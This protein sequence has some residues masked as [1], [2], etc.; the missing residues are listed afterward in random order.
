M[1]Q[2]TNPADELRRHVFLANYRSREQRTLR[3]LAMAVLVLKHGLR[4]SLLFLPLY[5][6]AAALAFQPG[7]LPYVL[8]LVPGLLWWAWVQI[9]GALRDYDQRVR[10][11]LLKRKD[12]RTMMDSTGED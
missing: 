1:T 6:I 11:R 12:L 4:G 5:L 3:G 7:A 9:R 8:L 10:H 2:P